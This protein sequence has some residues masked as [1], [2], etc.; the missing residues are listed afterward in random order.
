M[1]LPVLTSVL[2]LTLLT[3]TA[4][5]GDTTEPAWNPAAAAK[6]LDERTGWWLSWPSASRG[7][8]TVCISCHTTLPF[9]L[10]RSALEE[11]PGQS[12][13]PVEKQLIENVKKRV[14]N[15]GKIV[16]STPEKNP[17][18]PFYGG[19]RRLSALGTESVLNALVLVNHDA[20]RSK[21]IL[22]MS[23]R[24]ALGH[25][26]EQQQENGAW[27]WL[28]FGLQPWEKDAYNGAALAAVAV[29]TAGKDYYERAD[30]QPKLAA[31]KKHL[32]TALPHQPLH[33]RLLG[34]WA[35][36]RLPGILANEDKK[37]LIDEVL[38]LQEADGGWK[39][40]KLGKTA[41]GKG[42][43][44]SHGSYP[45]GATSDGYAT[46]LVVLALKRSGVRADHPKLKHGVAWLVTHQKDGSWPINYPNL[47]RDPQTD[48]GK[49]MRDA[50]TAFAVLGLTEPDAP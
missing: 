14:R 1:R 45:K 4:R 5:A 21:G 31:L 35:S 48:T 23:A 34:L 3:G 38:H 12:A 50:A 29:G 40:P 33:H 36:S 44:H 46:G 42:E 15:W 22:S 30:L 11:R 26:W 16:D 27:L 8:H 32:K 19:K 9:A 13:G 43:W 41:G 18:V 6:Y 17:F 20:R 24:R 2:L 28:D 47:P 10:A 37:K 25:L 7:Q 49:F 39:L